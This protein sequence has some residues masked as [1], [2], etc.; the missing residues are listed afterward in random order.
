MESERERCKTRNNHN[1]LPY[2]LCCVLLRE[3]VVLIIHAH[4]PEYRLLSEMQSLE[5][6]SPTSTE[7]VSFA[8]RVFQLYTQLSTDQRTR[9]Q[10]FHI[11]FAGLLKC[12]AT[13]HKHDG[14]YWAGRFNDRYNMQTEASRNELL[15]KQFNRLVA[16]ISSDRQVPL[17]VDEQNT[18]IVIDII[19]DEM[20]QNE[21]AQVTWGS[22]APNVV[23][24]SV[25]DA[26]STTKRVMQDSSRSKTTGCV[27][28]GLR[29]HNTSC[30]WVD[31]E[32]RLDLNKLASKAY[33]PHKIC[34]LH[35][36]HLLPR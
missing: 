29:H 21:H 5:L 19:R 27:T 32:G 22:D 2:T 14:P 3:V 28:C 18:N 15:R 8:N 30:K 10:Y 24:R 6:A 23:H 20:E 9:G 11:I 31:A 17:V 1:I 12:T 25:V 33:T 7:F 13:V 36:A 16:D 26:S 34:A 4:K 35:S